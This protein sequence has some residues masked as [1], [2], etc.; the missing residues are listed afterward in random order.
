MLKSSFSP[1]VLFSRFVSNGST[2]HP[3]TLLISSEG[4]F[5]A[6]LLPLPARP[7]IPDGK[8]K[9][10]IRSSFMDDLEKNATLP[11]QEARY[12]N[13]RWW[14]NINRLMAFVGMV[15]LVCVVST[16]S[17]PGKIS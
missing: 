15:I 17:L 14:R 9:D 13:A 4:W 3:S 10:S 5:A 8:G 1:L 11:L 16:K 7:Y 12:E 6:A 2:S